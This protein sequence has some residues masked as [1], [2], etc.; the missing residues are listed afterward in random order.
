MVSNTISDISDKD[1][2]YQLALLRAPGIG[3]VKFQEITQQ[4]PG[5]KLKNYFSQNNISIDWPGVEADLKWADDPN[6]TL[7]SITHPDYPN[8][9][10]EIASA[11]P[12]LFVQGN[13]SLLNK[14]QIAMVG[15]RNPTPSG[16]DIAYQFA[17]AFSN[18]GLVVTSG[19]ALG[20]DA[21]SHEGVIAANGE[22][23][24]VMGTGPDII[25]PK[26]HQSLAKKI[27]EKGCLVTE[28]PTGVTPVA[29]NF[30]RRNRI[31]SG[32]SLGVLVV[33]A[34]YASGSL[35][36]AKYALEQNREVFAIPGSIHNPISRGCHLLI[37]QG[38]KLVETVEDV[39]EECLVGAG[40]CPALTSGP[41]PTRAT[42]GVTLV[43]ATQCPAP[44]NDPFLRYMGFDTTSVDLLINRSGLTAEEVSSILLDLELDGQVKSVPGGYVRIK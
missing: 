9:L 32:L 4:Y 24:A 22:T 14:A 8:R 19:L 23:I 30:P 12:I 10:K 5:D 29:M 28:F 31:I 15:S 42:H 25:Y 41:T 35:V 40:H 37:K 36:T 27:L 1:L 7:L 39:L 17:K 20:I 18:S 16:Q 26:R 21:A 34:A 38:A 3:P 2:P 44:T 43:G 11:P 13:I 6:N 33:E